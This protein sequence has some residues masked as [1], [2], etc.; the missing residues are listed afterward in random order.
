MRSEFHGLGHVGIT[1]HIVAQGAL[2]SFSRHGPLRL[3]LGHQRET[4]P[5]P[6]VGRISIW[7]G[8]P[9]NQLAW[10][11][12][13]TYHNWQT[14]QSSLP[15]FMA[16]AGVRHGLKRSVG[17]DRRQNGRVAN[18]V[19]HRL[20]LAHRVQTTTKSHQSSLQYC[21]RRLRRPR[22]AHSRHR[23]R[24]NRCKFGRCLSGSGLRLGK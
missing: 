11:R 24:C 3:N 12:A 18:E 8:Y 21:H 16:Q 7:C 13:A 14:L 22:P 4:G 23:P 1:Q 10:Q 9:K 15:S 6:A 2:D 19:C 17:A 5:A 20:D